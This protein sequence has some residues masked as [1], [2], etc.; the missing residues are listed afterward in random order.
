MAKI[1]F[2]NS[3]VLKKNINRYTSATSPTPPDEVQYQP[4]FPGL[5]NNPSGYPS[6]SSTP[7]AHGRANT[8]TS[9]ANPRNWM[10]EE[11]RIRGGFNEVE[12]GYGV[13]AYLREETSEGERRSNALI[14]SGLYNSRTGINETNVFSVGEEI[15]KAVDPLYGSI[16]KIHAIETNLAIFQE[17][18]VSRALI[19]KDAIYSAE[20]AGAVTSTN[21]VIGQVTPYVGDFGI[22]R[23]PESFAT[24]GYRRYFTD[25]FRNSV[26]RLSNDGLTEISNYGMSD[27]FR[28]RFQELDQGFKEQSFQ[29]EF[30]SV[31]SGT[32]PFSIRVTSTAD[33]I[34]L[35]EKGSY[36]D[37][38]QATGSIR[39]TIIGTVNVNTT[40]KTLVI[41]N[42][43][44][45]PVAGG[46]LTITKFI[47]DSIIGGWDNYNSHY[48]LSIQ[49]K[50]IE[51]DSNGEFIDEYKTL[52]FEEDINGW[53]TF[54]T[55]EPLLMGSNK[56]KFYSFYNAEIYEHD[57]N[58]DRGVF[59]GTR[60]DSFIEFIFNANPSIQ[61]VFKT[62]NY[63][64]SNG[65]EVES[66]IS[67]SEGFDLLNGNQNLYT[68][69]ANAIKSYDE[70]VYVESGVEYR[71]GFNRKEN[72]YFA[73]LV[74]NSAARPGEVLFGNTTTGIKGYFATV[75]IK[76]DSTTDLGGAKELFAVST[77]FVVSSR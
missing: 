7:T 70:G 67:D 3:F 38:P 63:E 20:G 44:G 52:S 39:A 46:D 76:T 35:I 1:K 30:V 36:I 14:Y 41:T 51:E 19:D 55:Y 43:P 4:V 48:V 29:V 74:N 26:M 21:L 23:D 25:R 13:R 50:A 17:N 57:T 37:I 45:T 71:V 22:S 64:G 9:T 2:F 72:K 47:K 15:T 12:V 66:I 73:N 60:G 68:D 56:G 42:D 58:Q 11:S 18:K 32:S 16:Q 59:Y 28:D 77:E 6:F 10:I 65:W 75:K 33:K 27:F 5:A 34:D 24:Y 31:T 69:T 8:T 40:N 54:Y 62:V 61:K 49:N 53:N